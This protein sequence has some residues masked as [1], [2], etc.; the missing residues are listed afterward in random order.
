M[1]ILEKNSYFTINKNFTLSQ[2]DEQ[3]LA[4]LYLPIL[5]SES[6]SVYQTLYQYTQLTSFVGGFTHD[7]ILSLLNISDS[8]FLYAR[9]K[10]EGIGLLEVYRKEEKDTSN[11]I[12]ATYL[13]Q[14]LPPASPKKF[15][16]DILLRTLL[17]SEVGNKRY[18]LLYS[19]FKVEKNSADN[20]FIN[21]TTPFKDVYSPNVQEGDISLTSLDDSLVDKR[22]K[23]QVSFDRNTLKAALKREQ[24]PFEYIK[25]DIKEI[26]NT[27]ALYEPKLED[28]VSILI[29]NTDSDGIFY[30]QK[31]IADI[32]AL[33]QYRVEKKNSSAEIDY[34]QSQYGQLLEKFNSITPE[35]YL[36]IMFNAKPALF[37]LSEVE[38]MKSD[39]GFSNGVIN[40]I[41]D[42]C[43]KKTNH[44]FNV[45]FIDKVAYTLSSLDVT[46]ALD[47]MTKLNSRDFEQSQISRK[48]KTTK[49]KDDNDGSDPIVSDED[50]NHL[51]EELKL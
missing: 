17:N 27:I 18:F 15:F 5:K 25:K 38:K 24:Y 31:F 3:V 41:L 9:T 28:V 43:L 8:Q 34:G 30:L 37:M 12:K 35:D 14:L 50:F 32:R 6:Y 44:E 29:Q 1:K 20:E 36:Y 10:L 47:A 49:K 26:E 46:D 4:F 51:M 2:T 48:R 19:F 22:Y 7:E 39:L 45:N 33:K 40:V 21:I 42:Y 23:T 13:Y 16:D 11:Q